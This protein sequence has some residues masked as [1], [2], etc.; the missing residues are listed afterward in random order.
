MVKKKN[1]RYYLFYLLTLINV[2]ILKF[3]YIYIIYY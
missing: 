1:L 2:N 3:I